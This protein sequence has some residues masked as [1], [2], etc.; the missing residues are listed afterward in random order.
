MTPRTNPVDMLTKH[1]LAELV[2][3]QMGV[4]GAELRGGRAETAP[5][6]NSVESVVSNW[7]EL[8]QCESGMK[9]VHFAKTV[10]VR[11]IPH[12][13]KGVKCD[14]M[15]GRETLQQRKLE[16]S[17]S[18]NDRRTN[19]SKVPTFTARNIG[20]RRRLTPRRPNKQVEKSK[21]GR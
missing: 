12:T 15:S 1:V 9:K 17:K 7:T 3:R 18:K 6:L 5:Q 4:L 16:S 20:R 14:R 19:Q 11:P 21:P 13:N 2:L 10:Q 8:L